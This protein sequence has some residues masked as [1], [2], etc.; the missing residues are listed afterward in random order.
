MYIQLNGQI[1]YYER[2]GEGQR[3]LL[4]LHGNG[5][6]HSI[7][8]E[9]SAGLSDEYDIIAPD[10]RGHGQSAT[11]SEYH[12]RDFATD[13]ILLIEALGLKQPLVLGFSD[14]AITAM[15]AASKR[16]EL[17]GGLILC[18]GNLTPEGVIK[19][20]YKLLKKAN[21][22]A[23]VNPLTKLLYSEPQIT[24]SDLSHISCPTIVMAGENDLIRPEE[25]KKIAGGIS[26]SKLYILAGE[27]HGSYPTSYLKMKPY[28]DELAAMTSRMS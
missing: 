17:F 25:T 11:P 4:L 13:L 19:K 5:E 26:G 9:L 8:D 28:L 10:T 14:G 3:P 7:F 6:S 2:T 23:K 1:I 20:E 22:K 16:P 15:L 12:Y 18:G 21:K 24:S 27:D